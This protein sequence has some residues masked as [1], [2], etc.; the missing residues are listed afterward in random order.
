MHAGSVDE[1]NMDGPEENSVN[2][3]QVDIDEINVT[4]TSRVGVGVDLN[5]DVTIVEQNLSAS[6]PVQ[7][8]GVVNVNS[9]LVGSTESETALTKTSDHSTAADVRITLKFLNDTQV[10]VI[11]QLSE[12]IADFKR[13]HFAL[14]ISENKTIRLIFNGRVLENDGRTLAEA[15]IF[16]QCVV[17]CLIV[18]PQNAQQ[19]TV[20]PSRNDTRERGQQNSENGSSPREGLEPGIS[21]SH[22][23][24][25]FV[26]ARSIKHLI[27]CSNLTSLKSMFTRHLLVRLVR[28]LQLLKVKYVP[29]FYC[30]WV[31]A[32]VKLPS[33]F[34]WSAGA[35][36]IHLYKIYFHSPEEEVNLRPYE[37]GLRIRL[38]LIEPSESR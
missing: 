23:T 7:L 28:K 20:V 10:E 18:T 16:D 14:E 26:P 22:R 15:G 36:I 13:R 34:E 37:F 27:S 19:R 3:V 31:G 29:S 33:I 9:N 21:V 8:E 25:R 6:S 17:H 1:V 12:K 11:T 24:R 32:Y 30:V 38:N 35:Y 4:G 5:G 2:V